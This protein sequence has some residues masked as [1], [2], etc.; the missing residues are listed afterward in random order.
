MEVVGGSSYLILFTCSYS[1]TCSCSDSGT[2][3]VAMRK[4]RVFFLP[5]LEKLK[6]IKE[7][8]DYKHLLCCVVNV[9]D[10]HTKSRFKRKSSKETLSCVESSGL[11][12]TV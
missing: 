2:L 7:P 6:K 8:K 11:T 12:A 5:L 10:E 9:N 1:Y 3:F 4:D